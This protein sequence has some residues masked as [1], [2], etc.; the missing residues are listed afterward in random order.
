M[1]AS[2]YSTAFFEAQREESL[3]SARV[4]VPIVTSLLRPMSAVDIGCGVGAWLRALDENGVSNYLGL[5]GAYVNREQLLIPPDRF[6]IADLSESP[7]LE[8]RSF[9]LA[10]CLEVGE[11]L[12][13]A[14]ADGL[15]ALLTSCA[16]A[17]LFS[18]A[19]PSQG[20]TGHV[21]EQ[22]PSFWRE[23]FSKRGFERLDAIRPLVWRNPQ[24]EWWYKQNIYLYC[25]T[26]IIAASPALHREA[27]LSAIAPFELL[28]TDILS[29]LMRRE[30]R[31]RSLPRW[32]RKSA[33]FFRNSRRK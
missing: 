27:E 5:D 28:H 8:G 9:D 13:T 17:V 14:V 24:V 7:S 32:I 10:L 21:N 11:H 23:R 20:G 29:P 22:W 30:E 33:T 6:Q 25:R 2:T 15:V 31:I 19:V 16:P 12:S 26:D 4:I 18:A 1:S 3:R